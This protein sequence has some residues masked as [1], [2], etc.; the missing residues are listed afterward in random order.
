MLSIFIYFRL[1]LLDLL[2]NDV[3]SY[4]VMFLREYCLLVL[5]WFSEFIKKFG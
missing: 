2:V 3:I 4:L 1:F 5:E